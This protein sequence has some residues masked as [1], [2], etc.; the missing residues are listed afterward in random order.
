MLRRLAADCYGQLKWRAP[1]V[2]I[3]MVVSDL[4]EGVGLALL[5]PV[6]SHVSNAQGTQSGMLGRWM[7]AGLNAVGLDQS[8]TSLLLVIVAAVFCQHAAYILASWLLANCKS[9]YLT[10]WRERLF[11]QVFDARWHFFTKR[12]SGQI[13]NTIIEETRNVAQL[14]HEA[15][16]I[17]DSFII[18]AVYLV[19]TFTAAWQ[20][21]LITMAFGAVMF[22]VTSP[23][24]RRGLRTGIK[25][26]ALA[27]DL[28]S[29]VIEFFSGAK[30]IKSTA[31]ERRA[32]EM[33]QGAARHY[34][35]LFVASTFHTN[36]IRSIYELVA[37]TL[38]ALCL[39]IG[40]SEFKLDFG[41]IV[42][43]I[44][45]FLR[46]YQR[47]SQIQQS[48]QTFQSFRSAFDAVQTLYRAASEDAEGSRSQKGDP[49]PKGTGGVSINLSDVSIRY[50][51]KV[52]LDGVTLTLPA[53]SMIGIA[54]PSG[55]GKSTLVDCILGLASVDE[56]TIEIE[57]ESLSRLALDS[58]RRAVGYVA[59][60]TFLFN[61]SVRDNVAWA[62]PEAGDAEIERAL[63]RAHA[64][65]F[66]QAL[67]Q[68]LDTEVGERG[69]R[70]S[71]GQ[72][73]RIGLARALLGPVRLLV[74][75]EATSA[76]DSESEKM[77]YE[78]IEDLRGQITIVMVAHRLSTMRGADILYLLEEGKVVE[79]GSWDA[80]IKGGTRFGDFWRLQSN[81]SI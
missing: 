12:K 15:A 45:L 81:D 6:L 29:M 57:G 30:L 31:S 14:V 42:L 44:Y 53:S 77:V 43:S 47:L 79:S 28:Q 76:L 55:A 60:E 27:D 22:L 75:D 21:A 16:R 3:T 46:V 41:S 20:V 66:V 61:T 38:L 40:V 11:K 50:D 78:A 35:P 34:A 58:W 9:R 4:L 56:G 73:Q 68:G 49:L 1:L 67:P 19:L 51:G 62:H 7:S 69:V 25:T 17:F 59:Q 71:G 64:W 65:E 5:L 70:L 48:A 39:G 8:L 33:F 37:I 74:L 72:R 63:R 18:V 32:D 23:I 10:S 13:A 52:A 36:V 80:L 2:A 54:G 26:R 24:L